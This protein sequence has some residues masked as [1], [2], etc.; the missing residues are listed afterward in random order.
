MR[1]NTAVTTFNV[2][3]FSLC[4][5]RKEFL[6]SDLTEELDSCHMTFAVSKR[7]P[8]KEEIISVYFQYLESHR[9]SYWV[10]VN[11]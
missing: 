1:T 10:P 4:P 3:K 6:C 2:I 8:L 5:L 7:L 9:A 11:I